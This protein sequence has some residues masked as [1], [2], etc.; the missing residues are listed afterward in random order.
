MALERRTTPPKNKDELL[1]ALQEE[2]VI[3]A[4]KGSLGKLVKSMPKRI[5]EIIKAD[6]MPINY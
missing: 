3:L 2:W 1:E 4:T 6:G 5:R